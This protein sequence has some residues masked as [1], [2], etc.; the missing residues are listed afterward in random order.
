M[1]KNEK[2]EGLENA[3]GAAK[4]ILDNMVKEILTDKVT[5]AKTPE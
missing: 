3:V 1:Q 4:I 5:F 2:R